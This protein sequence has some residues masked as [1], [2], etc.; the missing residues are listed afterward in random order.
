MARKKRIYRQGIYIPQQRGLLGPRHRLK[1]AEVERPFDYHTLPA[2]WLHER[3]AGI[4]TVEQAM[5]KGGRRIM[6]RCP[7]C[8]QLRR[9]LYVTPFLRCRVCAGKFYLSRD[10]YRPRSRLTDAERQAFDER[11]EFAEYLVVLRC[12]VA[13]ARGMVNLFRYFMRHA[14]QDAR[15]ERKAAEGKV[16]RASAEAKHVRVLRRDIKKMIAIQQALQ[17]AFA[18]AQRLHRA[19]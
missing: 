12:Q 1:L 3:H 14:E 17:Q 16:R 6:A 10:G 8:L 4:D 9:E 19:A 5:P 18:E 2:R 15:R 7:Q 11:R 13:A